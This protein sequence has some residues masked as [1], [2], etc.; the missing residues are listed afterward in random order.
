MYT[1]CPSCRAAFS[2]SQQ[3]L[4]IAAGVVRCGICEHVFDAKLFLFNQEPRLTDTNAEAGNEIPNGIET[5]DLELNN[6]THST[7][8]LEILDREL[9]YHTSTADE[10]IIDSE[11][12][13]DH[14]DS[15]IAESDTGQFNDEKAIPKII[16]DQ[17]SSLEKP[18]PKIKP[19]QWLS[20]V[21]LVVLL[22]FLGIQTLAAFKANL[23]PSSYQGIICQWL[24]CSVEVPRALDKIEVLNRSIYTHPTQPQ[25][26]MVTLTII[27][28]APFMQPY[29]VIQLL[30]LNTSGDIIA[31]RQF[32]PNHYLQGKWS[33]D[34]LMAS[35]TP[36]SVQLEVH[37]VGEEVVSYN[38]DF[39]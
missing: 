32:S 21:T 7:I 16:A 39:F 5:V 10:G 13:K 17:I 27:N 20:M 31:A 22:V 11:R 9:H 37:D 29:P 15:D 23:I 25:A 24:K 35:M 12:S 38:F 26:L 6:E 19:A 1:R 33:S 2:I 36:L 18:P 30:F 28:R 3:Q 8:D 14:A 4:E 34:S